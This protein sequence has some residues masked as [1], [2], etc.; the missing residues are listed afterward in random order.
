MA[1]VRGSD[2]GF[3]RLYHTANIQA[4]GALFAAHLYNSFCP[5]YRSPADSEPHWFSPLGHDRFGLMNPDP[6][7]G[8]WREELDYDVPPRVGLVDVDGDGV[9]E[10]GY[11]PLNDPVFRCRDLWTGTTKWELRLPEAP[12]APVIAADVDGDGKGEFLMGRYCLGTDAAGQGQIRWESPVPLG[13]AVIADFDGDGLGEIACPA[14]GRICIL[15]AP[16]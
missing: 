16:R 3:A 9:M 1:W 12:N 7:T 4:E 6:V 15:K 10:V 14:A 13:W 8:P 5:V 11:A 2:A